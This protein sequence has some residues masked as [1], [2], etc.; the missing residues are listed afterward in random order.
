MVIKMGEFLNSVLSDG[1]PSEKCKVLHFVGRKVIVGCRIEYPGGSIQGPTLEKVQE[2]YPDAS[3]EEVEGEN[4]P[5]CQGALIVPTPFLHPA[6]S[7]SAE[8][9][10]SAYVEVFAYAEQKLKK[11]RSQENYYSSQWDCDEAFKKDWKFFWTK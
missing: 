11:R 1:V 3:C 2:Y 10:S 4:S 5:F 7:G 9:I 8:E 6:F